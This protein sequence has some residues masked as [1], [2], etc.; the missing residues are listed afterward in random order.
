MTSKADP[1][2]CS[3]YLW[4]GEFLKVNPRIRLTHP[5]QVTPENLLLLP[6]IPP[7]L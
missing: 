3:L 6:A 7:A 1:R 5:T 4:A 2:K